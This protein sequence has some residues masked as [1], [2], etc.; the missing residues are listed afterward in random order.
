MLKTVRL[1]DIKGSMIRRTLW[2]AG[3][4]LSL[5]FLTACGNDESKEIAAQIDP[6]Q[7]LRPQLV[8]GL[9]LVR[10]KDY[11]KAMNTVYELIVKDSKDAEAY[12]VMSYIYAKSGRYNKA[13]GYSR[14][15]L[16]LDPFQSLPLIVQATVNFQTSQFENALD[17]ARRALIINPKASMAYKV[18]GEVYI[19]QGF[20]KDAIAVLK[21]AVKLEPNNPDIL[22]LL[23]SGYIKNKQHDKAL[24]ILLKTQEIDPNV[25]G[26]NFNL[27][28]VY[29][30]LQDG[31]KAIKYISKA[32]Y[33]YAQ[34]NNL[35]WT[36]KSR[37]IK[38]VIAKK[39]NFTPDDVSS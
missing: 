28:L 13:A 18:I 11:E 8:E 24:P 30:K 25:P 16:E 1:F 6:G 32:E 22:N 4:T 21:E 14:R 36:G 29:T 12:S 17:L 19:R 35:F 3:V 20:T 38:R 39:F 2:L 33:L 7:Q 5:V 34:E 37:D 10:E 9:K 26:V 31:K 23:G 15:A 27:A